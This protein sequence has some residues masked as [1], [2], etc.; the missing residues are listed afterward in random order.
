MSTAT[1][2]FSLAAGLTA[3]F[4]AALALLHAL[5]AWCYVQFIRPL[6]GGMLVGFP[7]LWVLFEWLRDWFLHWLPLAL[8]W[9]RPC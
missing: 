4:C 1:P 6:P 5:F 7:A 3:L 9:L 2:A 8:S